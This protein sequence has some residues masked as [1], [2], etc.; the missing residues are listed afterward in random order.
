MEIDRHEVLHNM[1][2]E[3]SENP[4]VHIYSDG[5]A[6]VA[7]YIN[8]EHIAIEGHYHMVYNCVKTLTAPSSVRYF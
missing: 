2:L 4:Y 7:A 1:L 3:V 5:R 6:S 8:N